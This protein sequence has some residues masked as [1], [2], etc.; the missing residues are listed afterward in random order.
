VSETAVL[1]RALRDLGRDVEFPRAPDLA[2]AV[3]RR[4]RAE[5]APRRRPRFAGRPLALG[6]AVLAAAVAAAF[7]VP[8]TRA[9]ILD[10]LGIGGATIERVETLPP[11]EERGLDVPGQPVS[12]EEAEQAAA[13]TLRAPDGY[14]AIYLDRSFRGGLVSFVDRDERLVLTQFRGEATPYIQKSTAP[15][16]RIDQVEVDERIGYWLTGRRHVVVFADDSGDVRERRVAGNVLLWER[17]GITYRLEGART[18]A[19]ALGVVES[20]D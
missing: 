5:P 3:G 18:L 10:L 13:F 6:L 15:G 19:Q 8:Q 4:L 17:D 9:A 1:E 12:L 20:L 11:A 2:D 16:T 7:A 14:D